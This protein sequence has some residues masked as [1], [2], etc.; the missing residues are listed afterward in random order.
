M[1]LGSPYGICSKCGEMLSKVP[2]LYPI[3][4]KHYDNNPCISLSWK[5]LGQYLDRAYRLTVFGYNAP[6]SDKAAIKMLKKAWGTVDERN[7]EEIEIIDIKS[8]EDVVESWSEFIHTHHYSVFNDFFDSSLCKFPRRTCELLFDNTQKNRWIHG[9]K[10]FKRDMEFKEIEKFIQC[11]LKDEILEN[12]ILN[13][14]Y[15]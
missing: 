1:V 6:K 13:D 3:R 14:P 5:Q 9:D 2:L 10:G 12:E 7:L 11:L 8:E 4:E 15:V